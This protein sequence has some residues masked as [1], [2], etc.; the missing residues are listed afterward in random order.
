M[1]RQGLVLGLLSVGGQV[2][3]LRELVSSLNGDELFIGTAL[4]GWLIA[5]AVG[6]FIGGRTSRSSAKTLFVIGAIAIPIMIALVRLSPLAF[7]RVPG[8]IVPF[9][10]AVLLSIVAMAPVGVISGW[11]FSAIVRHGEQSSE[12]I[13]IVYLFEGIGAFIAGVVITI[14]SSGLLST[15]TIAA[16]IGLVVIVAAIWPS[17]R[18]GNII[19]V[20]TGAVAVALCLSFIPRCDRWLDTAKY[21]PYQ[22]LESFDTPYGRQA[23]ISRDSSVV[24][25]TD[26][27]IEAVHPDPETDEYQFLP[28]LLYYPEAKRILFVGRA[29]FGVGQLADS[30]PD[31]SFT[32]LDRRAGLND[33]LAAVLRQVAT[34]DRIDNDPVRY[35]SRTD[36]SIPYDIIILNAGEPDNYQTSRLYGEEFLDIVRQR[37]KDDGILYI[38]T[39][40]D[41]DRYL[42]PEKT[43]VLAIISHTLGRVFPNIEVWPGSTTLFFASPMRGFDLP[44]DSLVARCGR[45][46]ITPAYVNGDYLPDRMEPMK[47]ERL[48]SALTE[49]TEINSMGKPILPHYQALY[50]S[51]ADS[52]D[53]EV[54]GGILRHPRW[55]VIV[56]IVMLLFLA[57]TIYSRREV[58]RFPLFLFFV[59]GLV[60]M[61]SELISFY[62][63]QSTAGSLYSEMAVLIG[64]FMLG[65]AVGTYHAYGVGRRPVEYMALGLM[66]TALL[67]FIARTEHPCM[68]VSSSS[69][70]C[71]CS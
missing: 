14:F 61:T 60:S 30:F 31:V 33:H 5:V 32:A 53:R 3:L 47:R 13:I 37:L 10:K 69:M 46:P 1:R 4:F 22:M 28:P 40:Y 71:F 9:I 16:V 48:K 42:G 51:L 39:R 36:P 64:A 58:N 12:A 15:L 44:L 23:L 2:L 63:F 6:A 70:R 66:S 38:P 27:A 45:L 68:A 8:E 52:F 26:N 7:T 18:T 21:A 65:L 35:L 17:R 43:R 11:L 24:L 56:P 54:L 55:L 29:E 34:V 49:S 57:S 20:V 41:T 50:R 25:L 59:A 19:A 67:L 62:L